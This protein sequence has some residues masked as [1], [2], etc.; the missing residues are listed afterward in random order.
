ME[1]EKKLEELQ[2]KTPATPVIAYKFVLQT[3]AAAVSRRDRTRGEHI[4]PADFIRTMLT[5]AR[6]RYG[7]YAKGLFQEWGL[8]T[9]RDIGVVIHSLAKEGLLAVSEEDTLASFEKALDLQAEMSQPS[10]PSPPYPEM[11]VIRKLN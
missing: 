6:E 7:M 2:R 3:V 1:I 8:K 9:S 10:P 4:P 11:P 5:L